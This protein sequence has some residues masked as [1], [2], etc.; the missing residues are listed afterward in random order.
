MS[1][2]VSSAKRPYVVKGWHVGAAVVAFFAIVVGVDAGFLV[3][4]YRSHPGQVA[5]R[6]YEAGLIYNAELERLRAQDSLG[7]RA[8][9][10]ARPAGLEVVMQDRDGRPLSGLRIS[11]TLQRPA[12]EQG[13]T[14]LVLSETA[15]GVYAAR[16][17]LSGAWDV[18]IEAAGAADETLIAERRLLWP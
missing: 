13:R 4:A 10:A 3:A 9:A 2:P 1:P 14:E 6:P 15:P 7:W 8:G 11:A 16:H 17:G 12:T 5:P 18:R